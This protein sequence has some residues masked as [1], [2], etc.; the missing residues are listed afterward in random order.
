MNAFSATHYLLAALI[1]LSPLLV[2]LAVG[3]WLHLRPLPTT[4]C[5]ACDGTLQIS[6]WG[7]WDGIRDGKR[8]GGSVK[9]GDCQECGRSFRRYDTLVN[10]DW[11]NGD[12]F[13]QRGECDAGWW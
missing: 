8:C 10:G 1:V 13:E 4:R 7:L 3:L 2:Y 5:P 6:P 12:W 9:R 11:V